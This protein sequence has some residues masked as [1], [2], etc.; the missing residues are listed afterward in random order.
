MTNKVIFTK[1]F[2]LEAIRLL[3]LGETPCTVLDRALLHLGKV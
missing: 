1:E 3:E 2:K